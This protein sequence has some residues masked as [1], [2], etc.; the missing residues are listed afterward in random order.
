MEQSNQNPESKLVNN[1][2]DIIEIQ[3]HSSSTP[4][5]RQGGG[6]CGDGG[7]GGTSN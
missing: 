7:G 3:G 6:D 4:I 5:L 2:L 1:F